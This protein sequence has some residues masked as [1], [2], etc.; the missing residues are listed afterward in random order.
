VERKPADFFVGVIDFFAVLLPGALLAALLAPWA[1]KWLIGSVFPPLEGDT[2]PWAAFLFA[3]YLLGHIVFLLASFLDYLYDWFRQKVVPPTSDQLY[4]YAT[5]LKN[6]MLGKEEAT[7]INTFRWS[8]AFLELRHSKVATEVHR[9]EADSKFFRSFIIVLL[10]L[11]II[12][13]SEQRWLIGL[14]AILLTGLSF[15]RY[16]ERRW[17]STRMAYEYLITA[18]KTG[19]KSDA[20]LA[21]SH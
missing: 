5:R 4:L 15:W 19:D 14:I 20:S 7:L 2:A 12:Q 21:S 11:A 1:K 18:V 13:L 16:A 10:L 17:K 6:E 8:K 3:S 9:F